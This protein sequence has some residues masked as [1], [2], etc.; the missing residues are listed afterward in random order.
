MWHSVLRGIGVDWTLA[1]YLGAM[2]EL[3]PHFRADDVYT[4]N[5]LGMVEA[6]ADGVITVVDWYHGS[7]TPPTPTPPSDGLMAVPGRAR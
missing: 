4:G 6:V 7:V 1:D 3:L 5:Y 2:G